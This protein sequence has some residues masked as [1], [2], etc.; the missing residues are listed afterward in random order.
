MGRVESGDRLDCREREGGKEGRNGGGAMGGWSL[1]Y[2]THSQCVSNLAAGRE[3]GDLVP[4]PPPPPPPPPLLPPTASPVRAS[5][6]KDRKQAWSAL[7]GWR[8]CDAVPQEPMS[9]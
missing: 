7:A 9:S 6:R 1:P 5:S 4:I 3:L 8:E 2:L